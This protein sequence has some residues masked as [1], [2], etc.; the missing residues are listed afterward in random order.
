MKFPMDRKALSNNPVT[1]EYTCRGKRVRKTLPDSFKARAFYAAKHRAGKN[2]E[3]V[4]RELV[5]PLLQ[6][7]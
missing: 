6:I 7:G 4:A 1:I 3:V 2:P 5:F